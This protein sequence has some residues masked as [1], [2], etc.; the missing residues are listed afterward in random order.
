MVH[1]LLNKRGFW[2]ACRI[3]LCLYFAGWSLC[4]GSAQPLPAQL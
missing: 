3:I 1:L 2:V 4:K